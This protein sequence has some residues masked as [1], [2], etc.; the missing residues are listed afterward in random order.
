LSPPAYARAAAQQQASIA[1]LPSAAELL[2]DLTVPIA[3]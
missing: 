3:A 1:A 2:A